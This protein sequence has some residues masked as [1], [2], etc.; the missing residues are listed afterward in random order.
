MGPG[1]RRV[2]DRFCLRCGKC[3]MSGRRRGR[4]FERVSGYDRI[5]TLRLVAVVKCCRGG[6]TVG[7]LETLQATDQP[8]MTGTG[9]K[10]RLPSLRS[11]ATLLILGNRRCSPGRKTA[12]SVDKKIIRA[13]ENGREKVAS[14]QGVAE[15]LGRRSWKG[16][17]RRQDERGGNYYAGGE[18]EKK[19]CTHTAQEWPG[20]G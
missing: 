15:W 6:D 9:P 12:V 7:A 3:L 5:V 4:F 2:C 10:I 1:R 16:G 19:A 13:E 17:P 20:W 11:E 8:P 18:W 14:V